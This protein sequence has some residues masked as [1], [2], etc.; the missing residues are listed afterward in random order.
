[1]DIEAREVK[2]A[3]EGRDSA[4]NAKSERLLS[5]ESFWRAEATRRGTGEKPLYS[6]TLSFIIF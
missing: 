6:K 2:L 1:M 3:K 4:P 5:D